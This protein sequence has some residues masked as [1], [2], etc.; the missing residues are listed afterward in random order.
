MQHHPATFKLV[1]IAALAQIIPD[2]LDGAIYDAIKQIVGH[3]GPAIG[4][5]LPFPIRGTEQNLFATLLD[6]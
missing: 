2:I 1:A 6:L 3:L 4:K 5:T